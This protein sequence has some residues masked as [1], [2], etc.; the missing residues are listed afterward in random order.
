[1]IDRLELRLT[2]R[3]GYLHEPPY[4]RQRKT[5]TDAI[6]LTVKDQVNFVLV[7]DETSPWSM[8]QAFRQ[9]R[10][11]LEAIP[12]S[13]KEEPPYFNS[14]ELTLSFEYRRDEES[15]LIHMMLPGSVIDFVIPSKSEYDF[16]NPLF[17]FL[18]SNLIEAD[19]Y[20]VPYYPGDGD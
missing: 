15:G 7:E 9:L 16:D 20:P 2:L 13:W 18:R 6:T 8:P 19:L 3:Q 4:L 14:A 12:T 17:R 5:D 10:T 11:L 1:M